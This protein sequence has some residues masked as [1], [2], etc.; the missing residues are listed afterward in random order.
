MVLLANIDAHEIPSYNLKEYH[1][2]VASSTD[3]VSTQGEAFGKSE[4]SLGSRG[5]QTER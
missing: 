4:G 5:E 1:R 2:Q 3:A